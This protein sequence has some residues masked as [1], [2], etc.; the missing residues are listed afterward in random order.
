MDTDVFG[1]LMGQIDSHTQAGEFEQAYH[2]ANHLRTGI[3]DQA[4]VDGDMYAWSIYYEL[5]A[6]HALERWTEYVAQMNEFFPILF[7]IGPKNRAYASSLMMEALA[8]S[9]EASKIP[10]WGVET[11]CLRLQS[12]DFASFKMALGT[13]RYLLDS[14]QQSAL[15]E[16]F[17]RELAARVDDMGLDNL[18]ASLL[19]IFESKDDDQP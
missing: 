13:T 15:F 16:P 18:S 7:A 5:R 9:G 4:I 17:V 3:G 1:Q 19:R 14:H 2:I 11:C 8:K 6:L 12:E 10:D